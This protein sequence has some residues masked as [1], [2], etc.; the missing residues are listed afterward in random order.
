[1]WLKLNYRNIN[2]KL[3]H[4]SKMYQIWKDLYQRLKELSNHLHRNAKICP[5]WKTIWQEKE[6]EEDEIK[7]ENNIL[8]FVNE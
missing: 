4:G 2:Y 6:V 1:M 3:I 8:I 7:N 5:N